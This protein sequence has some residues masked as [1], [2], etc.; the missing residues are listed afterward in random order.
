[1][2]QIKTKSRTGR[3]KTPR[4]VEKN[5]IKVYWSKHH[6]ITEPIT[7]KLCRY[8][9]LGEYSV[10]LTYIAELLTKIT[11]EEAKQYQKSPKNKVHKDWATEQ[12]NKILWTNESKFKIF[13]LKWS[14]YVQKSDICLCPTWQVLT[15]GQ[16]AEGRLIVRLGEGRFGYK[17]T[18]EPCLT[19]L[20]IASL[21]A[22][23][24]WWV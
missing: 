14:V 8:P 16:W 13:E 7:W 20:V 6:Y 3:L 21:R 19:L 23:G 12:W 2:G 15:Q 24:T 11:S 22:M 17:P 9:L 10:K 18:L 1:M 4:R 5:I